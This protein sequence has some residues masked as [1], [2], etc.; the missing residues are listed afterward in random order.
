MKAGEASGAAALQY[1]DS[2]WGL[3]DLPH[4]W[5]VELPFDQNAIPS[6][7]YWPCGISWYRRSFHLST[8]DKAR[9]I[10]IQ[11]DG[12]A[13]YCTVWVNG[14]LAARNWCGY[15]SFYIDVT[16]IARFGNQ[17]NTI[18]LR[19]DANAREGW[20]Y[21][22]AGIY[23]HSWLVMRNPVH[24]TTNGVF[25]NPV[26][27]T[28]G[29]WIL[30]IEATL[31]NSRH[32]QADVEVNSVLLDSEGVE[33]ARGKGMGT[34]DVF[35]ETPIHFTIPVTSPHLWSVDDPTLYQVR[36]TVMQD[37]REIDSVTT[38]C[39]F[40][41]GRFDEGRGF[42]LNDRPLKI[43]G[44]CEHAG[45]AGVGVAVPDS[46]WEFRIRKLKEMGVNA[47]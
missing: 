10:E 5:M 14:I 13:T 1:N 26:F 2:D 17:L 8:S 40:R 20:W 4:D 38:H 46:L 45:H 23:R 32:E 16:P 6:Q 39:G 35:T 18:A 29:N 25:A 3:L 42:F 22:G 7:G 47:I 31:T 30:P 43:H 44:V 15:T 21:E 41:T 28:D 33:V 27:R 11:F 34:I 36:R 9:V 12:V 24:V 37:G 19:V